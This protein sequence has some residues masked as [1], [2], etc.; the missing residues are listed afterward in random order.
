MFDHAYV[1]HVLREHPDKFVGV[2]LGTAGGPSAGARELERLVTE[3]VLGTVQPL[4]VGQDN[5]ETMDR[6]G[7]GDVREAGQLGVP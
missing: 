1:S 3:E 2:L 5:G 7:P 4:P 6:G